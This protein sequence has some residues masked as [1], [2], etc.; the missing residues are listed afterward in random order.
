MS[1]QNNSLPD[2]EQVLKDM[3]ASGAIDYGVITDGLCDTPEH[4]AEFDDNERDKPPVI[5]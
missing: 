3:Q 1:T 2:P 5:D 4:Q